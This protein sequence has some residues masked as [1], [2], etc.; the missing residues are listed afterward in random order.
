[1][2]DDLFEHIRTLFK[3]NIL[4]LYEKCNHDFDLMIASINLVFKKYDL[5]LLIEDNI[6]LAFEIN[7]DENTTLSN[8][9]EELI[10]NKFLKSSIRYKFLQG[11]V[12]DMHI[13]Q[14]FEYCKN[15]IKS[16]IKIQKKKSPDSGIL[17]K[18]AFP[19][20]RKDILPREIDTVIEEDIYS[21]LSKHFNDGESI[22]DDSSLYIQ[23]LLSNNEYRDIFKAPKV[24]QVYRG[25][26]VTDDWLN[27]LLYSHEY[28]NID[29]SGSMNKTFLFRPL[30]N[31]EG[32]TSWST[33]KKIASNFSKKE[34]YDGQIS[35]ILIAK[36][37]DNINKFLDCKNGLYKLLAAS[38][39]EFEK[40][41]IG[42]GSI[43]ISSI[44]W[45]PR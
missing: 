33:D 6:K 24:K 3:S 39:F 18:W 45:K 38:G 5:F 20:K 28:K 23:K 32:S 15:E 30:H 40:E 4:A 43:M 44:E 29:Y 26:V 1:M 37:A 25:M 17:G 7:Y 2:N 14:F 13:Q 16:V 21:D 22:P 36:T 31:K 8:F 12:S 42:L 27:K 9:D 41:T 19:Q 34:V 10:T 11:I 35:L